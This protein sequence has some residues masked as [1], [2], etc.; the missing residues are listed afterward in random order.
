MADVLGRVVAEPQHVEALLSGWDHRHHVIK[1]LVVAFELNPLESGSV[2]GDRHGDHAALARRHVDVDGFAHKRE[3]AGGGRSRPT[4]FE[5][6]SLRIGGIADPHA[7]HRF[8]RT[9]RVGTVGNE[10]ETGI[11]RFARLHGFNRESDGFGP[12][13]GLQRIDPAT[14]LQIA[15]EHDLARTGKLFAVTLGQRF[16]RGNQGGPELRAGPA[17]RNRLEPRLRER[18]AT[19]R[20]RA[21]PLLK[22]QER[23]RRAVEGVEG[24]L[25]HCGHFP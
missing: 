9:T 24:D 16:G 25:V 13:V 20:R 12:F 14:R 22:R 7:H 18:R 19:G 3:L 15:H 10:L 5:L 8:G 11:G 21:V 23:H 4:K 6:F 1:I 2:L 17:R